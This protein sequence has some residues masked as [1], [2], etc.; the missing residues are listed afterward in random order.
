[1][2]LDSAQAELCTGVNPSG[3]HQNIAR[4]CLIL[5]VLA[6]ASKRGLRLTDVVQKTKLKKTVVHR[7]LAGLVCYDLAIF[8]DRTSRYF[9]GDRIF[10]WTEK[11][12]ERFGLAERVKP[13][14]RSLA[15]VL[16]DTCLFCIMRGNEMICYARAEGSFPIRTLTLN[17][18][19]RR[20]LG[21][22]SGGLAIAAFL[23]DE[24]IAELL[25]IQR[26]ERQ[27]FGVDD[28]HLLRGIAETRELGYAFHKGLFAEDMGGLAVPVRNSSGDVV[29]SVTV[30]ALR[31]RLEVDRRPAIAETLRREVARIEK[32]LGQ[33]LD[34][35]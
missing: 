28:A 15:D 8:D 6:I 3:V 34:E 31:S 12:K 30:N 20:P 24:R 13:Y 2:Y 25:E 9:I 11:A 10:G 27:R 18:G 5:E 1:L 7:A 22:G 17:A 29:A 33:L 16:E 21:V 23:S 19:T 4:T 32:D 26:E 14:I 35:L